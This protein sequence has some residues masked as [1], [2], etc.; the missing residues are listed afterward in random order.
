MKFRKKR[1]VIEAVQFTGLNFDEI[2]AFVGGD[3]GKDANGRGVIATLEGPMSISQNDWILKGVEG[4]FYPCKDAI[5][6]K[7]YEPVLSSP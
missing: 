2:E 4:E 1:I 6:R 5:F 7:T 3:Y